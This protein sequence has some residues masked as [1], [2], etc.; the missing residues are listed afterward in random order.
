MLAYH[1][2]RSR[3]CEG[4]VVIQQLSLES[5]RR[6]LVGL[7]SVREGWC[8][9]AVRPLLDCSR[10]TT[11]VATGR[12]LVTSLASCFNSLGSCPSR[13]V[14]VST[15]ITP[16]AT[17]A[18]AA[19]DGDTT[20]G[21][22]DVGQPLSSWSLYF[23]ID[24]RPGRSRRTSALPTRSL[25][26]LAIYPYVIIDKWWQG[27]QISLRAPLQGVATA[28]STAWSHSQVSWR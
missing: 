17:A 2:G 24:G 9:D 14:A 3:L 12:P 23:H 28:N 22:D 5:R 20:A 21:C 25:P 13:H 6:R 18:V 10:P 16:A 7:C 15:S 11:A 1:H 27:Q 26:R 4:T 8:I 19:D